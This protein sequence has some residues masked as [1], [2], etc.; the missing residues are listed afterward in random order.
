MSL[1]DD[2]IVTTRVN[3]RR[4]FLSRVGAVVLGA[5]AVVLGSPAPSSAARD[6]DQGRPP[7]NKAKSNSDHDKREPGDPK[8]GKKSHDS[9]QGRPP[10]NKAK[11]NSDHDKRERGDP[12]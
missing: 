5:A 11:S 12:K 8:G 9:D 6:T 10:D 2:E 1:N 7:D 4:S 3:S